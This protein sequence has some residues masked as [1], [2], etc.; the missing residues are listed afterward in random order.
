VA[1]QSIIQ[2]F[3][4]G[5]FIKLGKHEKCNDD[6]YVLRIVEADNKSAS[7]WLSEA[8]LVKLKNHI[9]DLIQHKLQPGHQQ[10]SWD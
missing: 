5:S 1:S 9:D 8:A 3:K 6:E 10:S 2:D 7:V 4:D